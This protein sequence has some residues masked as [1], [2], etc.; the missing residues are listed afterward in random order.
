MEL[1]SINFKTKI[2][3]YL[4]YFLIFCPNHKNLP[5]FIVYRSD[6][7]SSPHHEDLLVCACVSVTA[8]CM[9]REK[10]IQEDVMN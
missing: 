4:R 6:W 3:L 8:V 5:F 2:F 9:C 10:I 1:N 7:V